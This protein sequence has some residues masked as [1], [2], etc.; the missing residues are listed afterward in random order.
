[1][2]ICGCGCGRGCGPPGAA[3]PGLLGQLQRALLP[4]SLQRD[5]WGG[6]GRVHAC[7]AAGR[8]RQ[9][10]S[11]G[12]ADLGVGT[13]LRLPPWPATHP[14]KP[15]PP[16]LPAPPVARP[17]CRLP[18]ALHLLHLPAGTDLCQGAR[19]RGVGLGHAGPH[20]AQP[21]QAGSRGGACSAGKGAAAMLA[22]VGALSRGGGG[23]ERCWPGALTEEGGCVSPTLRAGGRGAG[24][25]G[26]VRRHSWAARVSARGSTLQRQ[27]L[28]AVPCLAPGR[29]PPPPRLL[30]DH[31]LPEGPLP[32]T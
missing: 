3:G 8:A 27:R 6:A 10:G 7:E 26:G 29:Y 13:H 18:P 17:P 14:C 24:R 30:D 22:C 23:G 4:S 31:A 11:R 20:A 16:V 28:G 9:S 19:Q 5:R 12:L 2:W 21:L 1:M 25:G 15:P 32:A